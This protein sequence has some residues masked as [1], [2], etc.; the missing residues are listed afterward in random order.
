[1]KP[2][3][4]EPGTARSEWRTTC[5]I[6]L[7]KQSLLDIA[8]IEYRFQVPENRIGP[9]PFQHRTIEN[10][11]KSDYPSCELRLFGAALPTSVRVK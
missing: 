11:P 4:W 1:M 10:H 6:G 3:A 9:Y 7:S 8:F 5:P 2:G